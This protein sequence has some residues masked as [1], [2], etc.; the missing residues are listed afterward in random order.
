MQLPAS[1]CAAAHC[2]EQ[3]MQQLIHI[4][5]QTPPNPQTT[6]KAPWSCTLIILAGYVQIQQRWQTSQCG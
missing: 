6:C 3:E 2:Q 5:T 1:N 4:F